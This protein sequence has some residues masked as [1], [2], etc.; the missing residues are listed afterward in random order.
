MH[1]KLEAPSPEPAAHARAAPE[2]EHRWAH[3]EVE[4]EPI[5]GLPEE[6]PPGEELLWQGRPA[7]RRLARDAFHVRGLAAYLTAAAV[8]RGV[9][10]AWSGAGAGD[11]ARAVA[12]VLPLVVVALGIAYGL[13]WLHARSTVYT[14]TSRRIVLRVG[15]ALPITFNLPFK[16]LASADGRIN[17]D[18]TGDIVVE[19]AGTNRLG[20]LFLW[21]HARPWRMAK[22]APMLRS[23]PDAQA[24]SAL[25]GE[26]A[27][28]ALTARLAS[29]VPPNG[30]AEAQAS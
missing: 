7:W 11:V 17:D 12:E 23:I 8:A 6:L 29:N 15:V 10:Y 24:V 19:L 13:A 25:L 26:A 1:A 5:P 21:P 20:W 28:H 22:A 14:L 16:Q 2:L 9:S 3:D 4:H 18:G 30:E 27:R